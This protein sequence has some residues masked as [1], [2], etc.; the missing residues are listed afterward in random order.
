VAGVPSEFVTYLWHSNVAPPRT[1]SGTYHLNPEAGR[2]SVADGLGVNGLPFRSANDPRV[3]WADIGMGF[4]SETPLYQFLGFTSR[5]DRFPLATGVEARLIEAEADLRAGGSNWLII[6]NTLR[7]GFAG[8]YG[9][10]LYPDNPLAGALADLTDPGTAAAREDLVF[11]E[12]AF[13]LYNTAHRLGDLRR[14]IRQYGRS[15]E[16]VFPTGAYFK[17]GNYG[18]DV[19]VPVPQPEENNPNFAQCLDRN[20]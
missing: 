18:I 14:L 10:L 16:S 9:P 1:I 3:P 15:A 6:L 20:P 11:Y 19:N 17:G 7:Q 13:W 12:R 2:W 8:T 5:T 4:D